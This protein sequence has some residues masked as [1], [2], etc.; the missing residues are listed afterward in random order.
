MNKRWSAAAATV[1]WRHLDVDLEDS[2]AFDA[3]LNSSPDGILDN[4]K[5]LV[6]TNVTSVE[7]SIQQQRRYSNLLRLFSVLPRDGLTSL[8]SQWFKF[9]QVLICVLISSQSKLHELYT[10][11]DES[12]SD[13]LPIPCI[14][15]NLQELE[16]LGVDVINSTHHTYEMLCTWLDHMPSLREMLVRGRWVV[17]T[18]K[19]NFFHGWALPASLDLLKLHTLDMQRVSLPN[20]PRRITA[21]LDLPSLRNLEL[22]HCANAVPF[23][24]SLAQAYEQTGGAPLAMYHYLANESPKNVQVA[25]AKLI[26]LCTGLEDVQVAEMTDSLLDLQCLNPSGRTLSKLNLSSNSMDWSPIYYSVADLDNMVVLCPNLRVLSI[27]LGDLTSS[28]H[29]NWVVPFRLANHTDHG[30]IEKLVSSTQATRW[31]SIDDA[32]LSI[33]K[34]ENLQEL[35]V[36]DLPMM[37]DTIMEGTIRTGFRYANERRLRYN[38]VATQF[39]ECLAAFGSTVHHLYFESSHDLEDARVDAD[40]QTWP[41][42]CYARGTVSVAGSRPQEPDRV[43]AVPHPGYIGE[44]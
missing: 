5:H 11:V 30:H 7:N 16:V 6:I 4:V 39:L 2:P 34:L 38:E 15:G 14:R 17:P 32:Q 40:G 29:L 10:I 13:Y 12:S 8:E 43:I 9:D 19:P 25:S 21:H 35:V 20:N 3:L 28:D 26:E 27:C 42:Y 18:A 22:T 36:M 23:L 33:A 31:T 1:L 44:K 41:S 24:S 37:A